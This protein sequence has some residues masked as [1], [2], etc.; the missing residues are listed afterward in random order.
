MACLTVAALCGM[1][2]CSRTSTCQRCCV[3]ASRTRRAR[4]RRSIDAVLARL[5]LSPSMLRPSATSAL[6]PD[7]REGR[8]TRRLAGPRGARRAP[9]QRAPRPTAAQRARHVRTSA[10]WPQQLRPPLEGPHLRCGWQCERPGSAHRHGRP[11]RR[12][13]ARP[14]ARTP[15]RPTHD[16]QI[17]SRANSRQRQN[18]AGP[19]VRRRR[20]AWQAHEDAAEASAR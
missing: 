20:S 2:R 8:L 6:R 9:A 15:A 5:Q 4:W 17:C 3:A 19:P 7:L 12:A 16:L 1:E 18:R 10:F 11:V 14:C 13:P